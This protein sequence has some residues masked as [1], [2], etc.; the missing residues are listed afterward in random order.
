MIQYHQQPNTHGAVPYMVW[1]DVV[2]CGVHEGGVG[3]A[4][5]CE[6][7]PPIVRILAYSLKGDFSEHFLAVP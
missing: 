4:L 7:H 2:W 1:C 6:A 3:E 5:Q